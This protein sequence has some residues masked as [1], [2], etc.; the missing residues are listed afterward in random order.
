V[1]RA[2]SVLAL[3]GAL[4]W[5][6]AS[7]AKDAAISGDRTATNLS[8]GGGLLVWSRETSPGTHDLVSFTTDSAPSLG[9]PPRPT[10]LALPASESP[11]DPDVG[12][13][14]RGKVEVVYPRCG[15]VSG[16]N[17]DIYRF[18]GERE[19]KVAG[20]S[21][22]RCSEFAP[23]LWKGT[24]AFARS[25]PRKCPGL[26]VKARRGAALRL[27]KRVPADT[28]IRAGKVAYLHFPSRGNS[29]IRLFT[30]KEGRSSVVIAGVRARGERTR[31]SSP[32]FAG[33]HLYFVLEDLR[34]HDLTVGRSRG[35]PRSQLEWINRKLPSTVDSIAVEGRRLF[36]TDGR[37]VREAS[38]PKPRFATRD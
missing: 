15:G 25:G 16:R 14:R 38:D 35:G 4:S 8:A 18:D 37:G 21:T 3:A 28:D 19:T 24:V 31:V 12:L 26:Y 9:P 13:V 11:F 34:R 36:F 1:F 30:I 27:D 7:L 20:A 22:R 32:T 17:C 5:A 2:V 29:I 23:S 6:A 10:D 33:P